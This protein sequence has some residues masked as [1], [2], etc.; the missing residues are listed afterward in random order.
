MEG[1]SPRWWC[2][3]VPLAMGTADPGRYH[4]DFEGSPIWSNRLLEWTVSGA[5]PESGMVTS[6]G[7]IDHGAPGRLAQWES[8]SFTPKRSG[9]RN[10]D[11]PPCYCRSEAIRTMIRV[12]LCVARP[13]S[14]HTSRTRLV[15]T[16]RTGVQ[17]VGEKVRVGVEGHGRGPVPQHGLYR[18]GMGS[19]VMARVVIV[20]PPRTAGS[21]P[22]RT[23]RAHG[24]GGTD[25]RRDRI[26]AVDRRTGRLAV[27]VGGGRRRG[28]RV[29]RQ[30]LHD[31]VVPSLAVVRHRVSAAKNG[32]P[33]AQE[34]LAKA[35]SAGRRSSLIGVDVGLPFGW[36]GGWSNSRPLRVR[37][38]T[39]GSPPGV[40]RPGRRCRRSRDHRTGWPYWELL[41]S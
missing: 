40:Q 19:V 8:A 28:A 30:E 12:A 21:H 39:A 34:R 18:L 15:Q 17:I 25:H 5:S 23:A 38:A 41:G 1:G 27:G 33:R 16:C 13:H 31:D 6:A 11:R 22:T 7:T 37:G 29:L 2:Q 14:A 36:D 24:R 3:A 4:A 9:V 32:G 10:P 35:E 20:H 26:R